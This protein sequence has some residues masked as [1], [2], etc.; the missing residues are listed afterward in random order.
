MA[1]TERERRNLDRMAAWMTGEVESAKKVGMNVGQATLIVCRIDALASYFSGS[2]SESASDEGS[3]TAF[4]KEFMTGFTA[5][6]AN[7]DGSEREFEVVVDRRSGT[8]ALL[9]YRRILY[10]LVRCGF[11]HEHLCKPGAAIIKDYLDLGLMPPYLTEDLTH[12]LVINLDRFR[13]DFLSAVQSWKQRVESD[14]SPEESAHKK[15]L[16][17]IL[18]PE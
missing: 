11:V 15:R 5:A 7:P 10:K 2:E 17:F 18:G 14:D 4:V 12:G 3:F 1:L 8:K 9:T 13:E 6:S 16:T